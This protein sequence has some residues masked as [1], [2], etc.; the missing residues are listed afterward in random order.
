MTPERLAVIKDRIIKNQSAPDMPELAL[1]LVAALEKHVKPKLVLDPEN[2]VV[3]T[4]VQPPDESAH[5]AEPAAEHH[6]EKSGGLFS[7]SKSKK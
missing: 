7:R 6:E 3:V 2:V 1:E 4:N 5:V